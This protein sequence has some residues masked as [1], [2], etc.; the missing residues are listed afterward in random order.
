MQLSNA[1]I[2]PLPKRRPCSEQSHGDEQHLQPRVLRQRF[3]KVAKNLHF[4]NKPAGRVG[5]PG[6]PCFPATKRVFLFLML[7]LL[8]SV[9]PI[10]F[11]CIRLI[12]KV[13]YTYDKSPWLT[14]PEVSMTFS[15]VLTIIYGD[16]YEGLYH[17]LF[18]KDNYCSINISANK[19]FLFLFLHKIFQFP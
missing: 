8:P 18:S 17:V 9:F 2:T 12:I 7:A 3:W 11:C 10:S 4:I 6:L 15:K 16:I 19:I 5:L 1:D 13:R 14:G